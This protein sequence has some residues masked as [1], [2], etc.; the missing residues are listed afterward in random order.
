[1]VFISSPNA[2]FAEPWLCHQD[3]ALATSGS[4][5]QL[6]NVVLCW[7]T[8]RCRWLLWQRWDFCSKL[9]V[10][11]VGKLVDGDDCCIWCGNIPICLHICGVLYR[12]HDKMD[13]FT[14]IRAVVYMHPFVIKDGNGQS[15][16]P[17]GGYKSHC[18]RTYFAGVNLLP[19]TSLPDEEKDPH[20][21]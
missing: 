1:M 15:A 2:R 11:P 8:K 12:I 9:V 17:I 6:G 13:A 18:N 16:I 4:R 20:F 7:G 21:H 3:A 5:R 19:E 10:L 14:Y